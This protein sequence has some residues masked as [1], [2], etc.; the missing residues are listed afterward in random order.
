MYA[1][2]LVVVIAIADIGWQCVN[3]ATATRGDAANSAITQSQPATA[4]SGAPS[5]SEAET[6]AELNA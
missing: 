1:I 4:N 6:P 5:T 2:G 3:T